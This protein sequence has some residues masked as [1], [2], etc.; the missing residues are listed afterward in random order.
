MLAP[1]RLM[2]HIF[3]VH[4]QLTV[5][6]IHTINQSKNMI[7]KKTLTGLNPSIQQPFP[8]PITTTI[9]FLKPSSNKRADGRRDSAAAANNIRPSRE[10]TDVR[11]PTECHRSA[12]HTHGERTH[13]NK[14]AVECQEGEWVKT[15]PY[16]V[17]HTHLRR[18]LEGV[19]GRCPS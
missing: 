18:S 1:H 4:I 8:S 2:S 15:N 19:E 17:P 3:L 9:L 6:L 10:L 11:G 16:N 12:L 14:A 7:A 13:C 5:H